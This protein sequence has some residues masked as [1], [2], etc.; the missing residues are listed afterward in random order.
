MI[1]GLGPRYVELRTSSAFSF[2]SAA[3]QPEDIANTAAALGYR[4]VALADYGGVY[5]IPRF[6]KAAK[7]AGIR[8]IVGAKVHL[9]LEGFDPKSNGLPSILFLCESEIG[10]ANLCELLTKAHKDCEKGKCVTTLEHIVMLKEGL[11]CLAGGLDGPILKVARKRGRDAAMNTARALTSAL[12]KDR[13]YLDLQ[14]HG[15]PI[16]EHGNRLLREVASSLQLKLVASNDVSYDRPDRAQVADVL[17]AIKEHVTLDELGARLPVNHRRYLVPPAE[18]AS[19][20]RDDP[21]IIDET[22]ELADRLTFTL[23]KTPYTFPHYPTPPGETMFSLLR[24]LVHRGI[25]ERYRPVTSRVMQQVAHEL[26][27]IEKLDLAGY[28][29]LVW[30]IGRFCREHGIL[31]QGRGSA[32]NSVVCYAL[33]LTAIDPIAYDLLFERFLSE[34]RGE[35]PDIDLDLPS[36]EEREKVIQYVYRRYGEHSVGMTAAVITYQGKS[37]AREVGKVLGLDQNCLDRLSRM[38]GHFEFHSSHAVDEAPWLKE[39]VQ[40]AGLDLYDRRVAL[41]I[42][43]WEQIRGLPRHISQHNGG[44][45]ICGG[46]LDRVVPIE[47]ATMPGRAIVQWDKDDLADLRIIKVDLLGLGMLAALRNTIELVRHHEGKEI[48][49]AHLP[50]DDPATFEALRRAD[51]VGVFQVES[52]A[53][54]ATLPR[55]KP[56][57][58]YDLVVEVAI[59]RPGPIVGKMVN[60]YLERRA[61]RQPVTYAHPDLEPILKRTLGVPLFQEQLMR[62]A[63]VVAGFTGGQA[64]ELRRAL[65]SRRSRAR[66]QK[67]VEELRK[68][69]TE[70]GIPTHVQNEIIE[71]IE[72]FA[73]YGFPESH[74]AS[75]ALIAYASAYLKVHHPAAFYCALLNC[76]P[77][78]F[79][80]PA[81][82]INDAIRH[83]I[84]VLPVDVNASLWDCT[85][86]H[87]DGH[88]KASSRHPFAVRLGLRFV[89][90]LSR[91]AAVRIVAEREKQAFSDVGDFAHRTALTAA[92]LF[93]LAQLGAL[94]SFGLERRD[95]MWQV[96]ALDQSNELVKYTEHKLSVPSLVPMSDYEK[97]VADF[98]VSDVTTGPHPFTFIRDRLNGVTPAFKLASL[99]H[100]HYVRVAGLVIVRQRPGT[101]KGIC[102]ATLEDETGFTNIVIMPDLFRKYRRLICTATFLVVDGRLQKRDGV[103]SVRADRIWEIS[104]PFEHCARDF[105]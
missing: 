90:G 8:P 89:K 83:G 104:A 13:L 101:A 14:R 103:V 27:V 99:P 1:D 55:M 47:P 58:F 51:T 46:R 65:G 84:Q 38:L 23:N 66:M 30:D 91:A 78:G 26:A 6:V 60:P 11:V 74:A 102:F 86:E 42:N 82:L 18:M 79:Y 20:F 81:T 21:R 49:L 44:L 73:L 41:F 77:M 48:D 50:P 63:M 70:R 100:G 34:E 56:T 5:G 15:D 71:S 87:K 72:G 37:A 97:M 62:M 40:E 19:L 29:L 52:R 53:Q 17:L 33:G 35:W 88:A 94:E 54:M 43:L 59:I 32:A 10:W 75:F 7:T 39:R 69:M 2:L 92:E 4:A 24:D 3:S 16:E 95:A 12:G 57:R 68:G 36:G 85:L 61:G 76:W 31:A 93:T 45:V 80:H 28:F 25:H 98:R 67:M 96:L 9:A 64:E 105:C 22:A